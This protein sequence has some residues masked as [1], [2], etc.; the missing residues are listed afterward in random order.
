MFY[1]IRYLVGCFFFPSV[2]CK[3]LLIPRLSTDTECFLPLHDKHPFQEPKHYLLSL[4][5]WTTLQCALFNNQ[6]YLFGWNRNIFYFVIS[7]FRKDNKCV[8]WTLVLKF[9]F[10][11]FLFVNKLQMIYIYMVYF[12]SFNSK[13]QNWTIK[14]IM[15]L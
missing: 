11:A 15:E 8:Y 4:A 9:L 13:I 12:F 3:Q 14:I 2:T 10:W 6:L 5:L 7:I 1:G